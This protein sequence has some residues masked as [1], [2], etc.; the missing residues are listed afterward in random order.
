[1]RKFRVLNASIKNLERLKIYFQIYLLGSYKKN[2]KIQKVWQ[3]L[4]SISDWRN[5][6]FFNNVSDCSPNKRCGL[7]PSPLNLS[8]SLWLFILVENGRMMLSPFWS[9]VIKDIDLP[10]DFSFSYER[11]HGKPE[12]TCK[13]SKYCEASM[14]K[15][16][17]VE[18]T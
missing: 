13:K 3:I 2:E 6:C 4:F 17:H 10:P 8:R 5:I 16:L 18:A 14:L 11:C 1:M 15:R 9:L 12:L 7:P